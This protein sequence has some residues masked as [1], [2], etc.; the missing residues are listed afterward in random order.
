MKRA[1]EAVLAASWAIIPE[2][3]ETI[4]SIAE[5]ESEYSGNLQALEAKL[6][7]PLGNTMTATVRDGVAI[8]PV[9]GP[10]F[11]R[12]NLFTQFS[13]ATSYDVLARDLAQAL[14]D[15]MVDA[16][17]LNIDSPGGEVTG[18]SEFAQMIAAADKPVWAYVGGTGASA[19]YWIASAAD[20]IIAADTAEIGS[21]GVMAG[22]TMREPRA[23]EKSYTFVSSQSPR[24]N[25]DPGTEAGASDIQARVDS[26]ASV[27]ISAVAKNRGISESVVLESFG[28]GAVFVAAEAEKRGMID[29]IG[30]FEKTLQS[31]RQEIDTMDYSAITVASLTEN[32]PEL[33]AEITAAALAG[34]EKVD[35][36]A[37]RAEGATAE[38]Q[39][40][41]E[42]E[43]LAMPGADA[44]IA[45][46]KADGTAP[47][48]AAIQILKA[49]KAGTI[50]TNGAQHMASLSQTEQGLNPPQ[51]GSGS[52]Q[53]LTAEDAASAAIALARKAGVDA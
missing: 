27:F 33:V 46:F 32:R 31:L 30:T 23:G 49:A 44:L 9:E 11:R 12:A 15:P 22:M 10:M 51:T 50:A 25:A 45:Q 34:V 18:T 7:R 36:A 42:I 16:V 6:G 19:A 3:L 21:I 29:S 53:E 35:L 4:A 52:D 13:G 47:E 8:I 38:R 5:R 26:L 14:A 40:I 48:A 28:A 20:R 39:R 43:A 37:V 24:K 41:A 1:I 2:W 17:L